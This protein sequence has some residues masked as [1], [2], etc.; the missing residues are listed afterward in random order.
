MLE[1]I[2]NEN[3]PE[4]I[5]DALIF[6]Y[7]KGKFEDILSRSCHLI[8][9]YSDSPFIHEIVGTAF[10]NI[11]KKTFAVKHFKKLI[12]LQPM[13]PHAYNKLG[14]ALIDLKE[15]HEAK[16]N[17][18]KSIELSPNYAD[19]YYKLGNLYFDTKEYCLAAKQYNKSIKLNPSNYQ[20]HNNLGMLYIELK[21]YN[22]AERILKNT[23]IIKPDCAEAYYNLGN[24]YCN[25]KKYKLALFQ[26]QKAIEINP[27]HYKSHHNLGMLYIELKKYNEAEKILKTASNLRPNCSETFNALANFYKKTEN[28]NK[29]I[30]NYKKAIKIK[31][32]ALYN[33]NIALVLHKI[34]E[35]KVAIKHL[36]LA[37]SLDPN[38]S[39]IFQTFLFNSNYCPNM[40]DIDIFSYYKQY[41]KKF[42]FPLKSTWKP[43]S[44][45]KISNKKL[46]IGYLSPDFKDHSMKNFLMPILNHHDHKNF[47]I[48]AFAEYLREDLVT[49]EYKFYVDHWF[50]TDGIQDKI[51][52]QKIRD[53]EIDILVD[54]AGYTEGNRL[55][56]FAYKPAPVSLSW[57]GYGYTTGLSAIDYIL[58]DEV[59]VPKGSE[60]LF[61]EKPWR[62]KNHG[63]CCYRANQNMGEVNSLPALNNNF[64]TFGSLTRVIRIN[65]QTIKSWAEILKR[66]ENSKLKINSPSFKNTEIINQFKNKFMDYGISNKRLDF[67]FNTPPWD[68][69]RKIDIALDCYPHNSGTTLIE[70]LYMGNPF[71]TFSNRPS[72][73]RIG[74][75]I[76]TSVGRSE[77]I[78]Y[79]EEE[80]I[81]KAV[82]LALDTNELQK[83]RTNLRNE[84]KSSSL[85]DEKGFIGELEETY[86]SMWKD[87]CKT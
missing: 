60:H 84:M 56:V 78:T 75:S 14:S 18:K 34:G 31:N 61:A 77:W 64:I 10:Y 5:I 42:A 24:L 74:A 63:F 65:D 3:V 66:V 81:N 71:I 57:L 7:Q 47:E 82:N 83:I 27:H 39:N 1:K 46:K 33:Y 17:L 49:Q 45:L 53:F 4:E 86:K 73:G 8:K 51:L 19:A 58:T 54:L 21:K 59:M 37:L 38:S 23:L 12:K 6:L 20:A 70:H 15:Y 67:H 29:A 76:L 28:Y 44:Q 2:K 55:G 25:I 52:A 22:E 48:Y 43:F 69:M 40:K 13:H 30:L 79:S 32:N 68:T 9:Y 35:I 72:V 85:M 26:Y 62:L 41:E 36:K 11:G 50:R 16:I 80:Y 87:W